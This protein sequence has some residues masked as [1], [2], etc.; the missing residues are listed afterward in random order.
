MDYVN[1]QRK[2]RPGTPAVGI[3]PGESVACPPHGWKAIDRILHVQSAAEQVEA[4]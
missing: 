1:S 2:F 3:V 4:A